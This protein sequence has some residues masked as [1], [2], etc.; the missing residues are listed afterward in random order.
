[1]K[2]TIIA[3][4]LGALMALS[5]CSD[6]DNVNSGAATVGFG[7]AKIEAKERVGFFKVPVT[8]T[9]EQN[10][11]IELD[12]KVLADDP[13]CVED[14]NYLITSKHLII[15]QST[16]TV[17]VEIKAVDDRQPN[18]DRKFKLQIENVKGA[19]VSS[20]NATAEVV[21]LDNDNVPYELMYGTWTL[22]AN[23][24]NPETNSKS[25]QTWDID[26]RVLEDTDP[27][28]GIIVNSSP[29]GQLLDAEENLI[30]LSQALTFKYDNVTRKSQ[31]TM[32]IGT[33]LAS[34]MNLGTYKDE[35]TGRDR[36][37][38]KAS[39]RTAIMGMSGFLYSG[40]LTG[41]VSDD[42]N[43]I[44]FPG[45]VYMIVFDSSKQPFMYYGIYEDIKLT[46]N[47]L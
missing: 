40:S 2:K 11:T 16:K 10:G 27:E 29:W 21:I 1:M 13:N 6:S 15:P 45:T 30:T 38:T 25:V 18:D 36:D 24:I 28:Y 8:V 41:Q 43:E 47:H 46:F 19:S 20:T 7:E 3:F 17:N 23:E 26:L 35:S 32:K 14:K 31:L 33:E 4:C 44:T 22:S 5:S 12:V 39:V 9:G 42:Y 34:N 37:L